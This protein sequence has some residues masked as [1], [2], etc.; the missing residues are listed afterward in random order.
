MLGPGGTGVSTY[1]RALRQAQSR[2][3]SAA[4]TVSDESLAGG[5]RGPRLPRILRALPASTRQAQRDRDTLT[6]RDLFR[7]AHVHF[8][9]HGEI[10]RLRV[11]GPPGIMH[12]TYPVP[13]WIEGWANLYTVHDA[14]PLSNPEL[15]P[16][17]AKRHRRLLHRIWLRAEKIIT[18]SESAREEIVSALGWEPSGIISCSQPVDLSDAPGINRLQPHDG[19]DPGQYLIVCGS[20]EPRKNIE[21]L[22]GAYT[23]SGVQ[24]PLIIAGPDGWRSGPLSALIASTPGVLRLPYQTRAGMLALIHHARALLMPSLA[25]G[26]GLPVVEA[27]ALGTPVLSSSLGALAETAGDAALLVNPFDTESLS[28]GIARITSDDDLHAELAR[29]GRA[30]VGRCFSPSAFSD[31]LIEVYTRIAKRADRWTDTVSLAASQPGG[32]SILR[33]S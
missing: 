22:I 2:I 14:I 21:R 20:I 25:E 15:S 29:K 5:W 9:I 11:P 30:R 24:L 10:L 16:I 28:Q 23:A 13:L 6:W 8:N 7:V 18:V 19:L 4:L 33:E 12:W 17:D 27:M 31:R 32:Q 3:S 26:Y 1:A